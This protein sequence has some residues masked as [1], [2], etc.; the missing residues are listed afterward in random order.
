MCGPALELFF[1]MRNPESVFVR[2]YVL[3]EI[4]RHIWMSATMMCIVAGL[5][6]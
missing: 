3:I 6:Q 2:I 5:S 4:G 1:V